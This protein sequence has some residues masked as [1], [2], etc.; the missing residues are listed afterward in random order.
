MIARKIL[1]VYWYSILMQMCVDKKS[2]LAFHV[3]SVANNS[4][5]DLAVATLLGEEVIG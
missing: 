1:P 4:E 2:R 5:I 3:L